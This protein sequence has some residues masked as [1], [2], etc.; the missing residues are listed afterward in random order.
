M[1]VSIILLSLPN[2]AVANQNFS[3]MIGQDADLTAKQLTVD[4]QYMV[5]HQIRARGIEDKAVLQAM[6]TVPRH[7][8]VEPP[9]AHLAYADNPLPISHDQT[10]SQPYIVAYMTEAAKISPE[11]RVLE[12]GTGCGYQAAI[13]GELAGEVY[14]IEI[15]PE[16]AELA[17]RTLK[18]LGYKNIHFKTSDGYWGWAE[19]APYDAI[20]VTAAPDHIPQPLIDQ[21]AIEGRMVIPVGKRYQNIVVLTKKPKGVIEER[22]IPVRFVPLLKGDKK[23]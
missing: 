19:H 13:L 10:I 2:W 3:S 23:V 12:I 15:I 6:L 11:D 14:T 8:F 20:L 7:R 4:R 18:T 17:H 22:T 9:L 16:L 1:F 5:E 21:L